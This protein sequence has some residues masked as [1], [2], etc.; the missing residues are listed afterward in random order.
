MTGKLSGAYYNF[1]LKLLID[2]F[3]GGAASSRPFRSF[4]A[5]YVARCELLKRHDQLLP[6]VRRIVANSP[7]SEAGWL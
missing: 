7:E 2:K 3:D 6:V 1:W 5:S 4:A